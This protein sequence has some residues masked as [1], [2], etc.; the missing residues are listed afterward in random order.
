MLNEIR[1]ALA[2]YSVT[3][4]DKEANLE[5]VREGVERAKQEGAH[6][7]VFPELFLTGYALGEEYYSIS[8][9]VP[10]PTTKVLARLAKDSDMYI[11]VGM[12]VVA[13]PYSLTRNS[14]VLVAPDGGTEVYHKMHLPTGV[15]GG[16][17]HYEGMYFQPGTELP[18]LDTPI[19]K[20]G[21]MVCMDACLP[22]TARV[23][24]VKG[25]ELLICPFACPDPWW[26][27]IEMICRVRAVENGV[28]FAGVNNIGPQKTLGFSGG[29][30]LADYSGNILVSAGDR[31]DEV[32]VGTVDFA[33]LRKYR[34]T[35]FWLKERKPW[36][37]EELCQIVE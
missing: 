5:K 20:L 10:G 24:A 1:V 35:F 2:Q 27:T 31:K 7:I 3:L 21:I 22:E 15:A 19:G 30:L 36:L 14:A 12:P 11:V 32:V 9:T 29:S 33:A 23:M 37:Y 8:E 13:G 34:P 17:P 26:P 16:V 25:A 28:Y 4:G 18:V 6:L